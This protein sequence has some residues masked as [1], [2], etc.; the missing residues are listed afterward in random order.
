MPIFILF[1][2]AGVLFDGAFFLWVSLNQDNKKTKYMPLKLRSLFC[3][4]AVVHTSYFDCVMNVTAWKVKVANMFVM[5]AKWYKIQGKITA[6][7]NSFEKTN[8]IIGLWS[9]WPC[10][11]CMDNFFDTYFDILMN[12]AASPFEKSQ[13]SLP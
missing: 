11:K 9:S 2:S 8:P 6:N 1:A 5:L 12:W 13:K 4:P 7:F 10:Q 3:L